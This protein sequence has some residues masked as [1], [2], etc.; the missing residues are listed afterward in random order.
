MGARDARKRCVWEREYTHDGGGFEKG[1]H[2]VGLGLT[3]GKHLLWSQAGILQPRQISRR[4]VLACEVALRIRT[5]SSAS[6]TASRAA[7]GRLGALALS[8]SRRADTAIPAN[9]AEPTV[10][11]KKS[12]PDAFTCRASTVQE[13]WAITK[14]KTHVCSHYGRSSLQTWTKGERC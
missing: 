10:M 9:M 8:A 13:R 12:G 1:K 14:P 3:K 11:S 7:D 4:L 2:T 5:W 6:S